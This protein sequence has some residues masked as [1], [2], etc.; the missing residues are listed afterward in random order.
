MKIL[1]QNKNIVSEVNHEW[2]FNSKLDTAEGRI[3]EFKGR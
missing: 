2:T 3:C 1:E